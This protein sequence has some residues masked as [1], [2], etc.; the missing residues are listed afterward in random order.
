[1]QGLYRTLIS[2]L[3]CVATGHPITLLGAVTTLNLWAGF[4]GCTGTASDVGNGCQAY[5]SSECD[6][7]VEVWLCTS[8]GTES[9]HGNASIAWP[10]LKQYRSPR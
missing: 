7:G 10:I 1:M 6:E 5:A 9:Q 8:P 4:D 2:G 3:A